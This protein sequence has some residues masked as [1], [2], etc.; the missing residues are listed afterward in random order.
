MAQPRPCRLTVHPVS[1]MLRA[2]TSLR[3]P[4]SCMISACLERAGRKAGFLSKGRP[5]LQASGQSKRLTSR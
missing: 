2:I 5:H 1:A 3:D 4:G